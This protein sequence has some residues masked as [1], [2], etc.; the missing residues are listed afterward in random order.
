M[1]QSLL[2]YNVYKKC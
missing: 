2:L 1:L